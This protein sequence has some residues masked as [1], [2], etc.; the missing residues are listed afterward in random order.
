[1]IKQFIKNRLKEASTWRALVGLATLFGASLTPEQC[2]KVAA[3]GLAIYL[4]IGA[5]FPDKVEKKQQGEIPT[6]EPKL[7]PDEDADP[8]VTTADAEKWDGK[9]NGQFP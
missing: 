3:A 7:T 9:V 8:V 2:D 5:L 1:M 6:P 4:A